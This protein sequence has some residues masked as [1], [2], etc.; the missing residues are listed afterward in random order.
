MAGALTDD[1]NSH[2][3]RFDEVGCEEN[4]V[5]V[6]GPFSDLT[7][8]FMM[9]AFVTED[10]LSHRRAFRGRVH[11]DPSRTLAAY[12]GSQRMRSLW[13]SS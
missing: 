7:A 11:V 13:D 2:A 12:G 5:T 6:G 9:R 4:V 8:T 10:G 3:V 1:E